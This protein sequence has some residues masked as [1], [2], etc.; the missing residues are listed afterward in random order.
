M[1]PRHVEAVLARSSIPCPIRRRGILFASAGDSSIRAG[2]LRDWAA[3][4]QA[5]MV[6]RVAADRAGKRLWKIRN[7]RR[8]LSRAGIAPPLGARPFGGRTL[9]LFPDDPASLFLIGS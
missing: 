2:N 3:C 9:A 6:A 5:A 1:H 7:G 4:D 8:C